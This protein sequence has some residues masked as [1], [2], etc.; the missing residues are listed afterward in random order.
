M[1]WSN[2]GYAAFLLI[3]FTIMLAGCA[4]AELSGSSD[5]SNDKQDGRSVSSE[6]RR[7][8]LLRS[9][10]LQAG[11]MYKAVQ[12]NDFVRA[13][14]HVN[15][16]SELVTQIPFNGITTIEGAEALLASITT[17]KEL[18]SSVQIEPERLVMAAAQVRLATD[19]LIHP[20][21]PMW[22]EYYHVMQDD[23]KQLQ[24]A[25]ESGQNLL[26][27]VQNMQAHYAIIRPSVLITHEPQVNEKVESLLSF[28]MQHANKPE[29]GMI[30]SVQQLSLV[31]DELF[32]RS[33]VSAYVPFADSGEPLYWSLV[34]GSIIITT[35]C[36]AAWR[37]YRFEHGADGPGGPSGW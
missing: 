9:L 25:I 13:R 37:R 16:L 33:N 8:Q 31:W 36:F 12:Q 35:L 1:L 18:L 28:F 27:A 11:D 22:Y 10:D 21:H 19:A 3:F 23:T 34:I 24:K 26:Q 29:A 20:N 5:R 15:H 2:K 6:E 7:S 30:G 17:T 32:A 14:E 4:S